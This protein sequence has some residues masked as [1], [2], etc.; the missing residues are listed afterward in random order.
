[1][2]ERVPPGESRVVFVRHGETDYNR[3]GRWQGS[4]SDVPLNPVGRAQAAQAAEALAARFGSR[5][6][7]IY[8]SDLTRAL[9]TAAILA[10][11]LEV[12]VV[13]SAALRELSHGAWEGRTQA[14][15]EA[16]WP[17]E[18]AAYAADPYLVGRGGG[19][20]YADLER[21]F[22][23]ALEG[24][25]GAHRGERVVAV[26]HGGPIRLALSTILERPLAERDA[27]GVGNGAWFELSRSARGWSLAASG[28]A[29][30][31]QDLS[32]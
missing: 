7:T 17:A 8:S 16:R 4:G 14:E 19:D 31:P 1:M 30:E 20:S 22:W 27:L 10:A 29:D 9:E 3:D 23:P 2:S 25:A 24:I 13:E 15:V 21:R 32:L 11:R 28:G 6:A 26:S 18:Y 12:S 5:I